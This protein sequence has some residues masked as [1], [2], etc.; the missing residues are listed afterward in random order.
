MMTALW[1][2]ALSVAGCSD[3]SPPTNGV[4]STAGSGGSGGMVSSGSGG[5]GGSGDAGAGGAA[6]SG[7]NYAE[8]GVCGLRSE[9]TVTQDSFETYEEYYLLSDEGLGEELCVVRYPVT[10]IGPGPGGCDQ[11]AGR[12]EECLWTHRVEYGKPSVLLDENGACENSELGMDAA[13][14]AAIEGTQK[15]YGYVSEYQGHTS[16]ILTYE[17][18]PQAWMPL[19]SAGWDEDTGSLIFDRRDGFCGY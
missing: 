15:A 7:P 18:D 5:S 13:R 6:G 8:L 3:D 9:G 10:R 2:A 12:Q 4:S 19:T 14:L 11:F 16:V 17:E 1:C